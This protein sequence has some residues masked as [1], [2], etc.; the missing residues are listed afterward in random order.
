VA[1]TLPSG[2]VNMVDECGGVKL[3]PPRS[4]QERVLESLPD[5]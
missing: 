2:G 4:A 1:V 3:P 5:E